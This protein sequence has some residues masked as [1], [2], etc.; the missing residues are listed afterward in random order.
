MTYRLRT[1]FASFLV[2]LALGGCSSSSTTPASDASVR[3]ARVPTDASATDAY[4]AGC[5]GTPSTCGALGSVQCAITSGCSM[6]DAGGSSC[7]GTP[8]AC[9]TFTGTV[10]C[11]LFGCTW[12]GTPLNGTCS[13]TPTACAGRNQALCMAGCTAVAACSGT[14]D[15]CSTR[16]SQATCVAQG[17][18][19]Q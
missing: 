16:T 15:A 10:Q 18:T 13:G 12:T 7:T 5:T 6:V 9:T 19:W 14:A 11:Q 4:V 8:D 2:V 3:D 17:C 1:S